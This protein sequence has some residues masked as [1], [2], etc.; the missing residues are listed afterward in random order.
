MRITLIVKHKIA[1]SPRENDAAVDR[2]RNGRR[3]R[4][5]V[6]IQYRRIIHS[7]LSSTPG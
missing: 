3:G 1:S 7:V 6:Q 2:N 4:Q 5:A